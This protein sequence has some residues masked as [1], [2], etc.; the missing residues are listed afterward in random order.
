M[1]VL[2]GRRGA[3]RGA[4][5]GGEKDWDAGQKTNDFPLLEMGGLWTRETYRD[6]HTKRDRHARRCRVKQWIRRIW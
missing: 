5:V 2:I 4:Q 1:G 6:V 3:A